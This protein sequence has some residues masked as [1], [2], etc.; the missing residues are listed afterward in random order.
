VVLP[1]GGLAC[2]VRSTSR[3]GSGIYFTYDFGR[4]WQYA[5]AGPYNTQDAGMLD[6]D[7]FWVFAGN[8]A[9]IYRKS[10]VN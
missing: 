7:Q 5:L 9:V 10:N 1:D 8:E 2:I 4:T 6:D 3:Q